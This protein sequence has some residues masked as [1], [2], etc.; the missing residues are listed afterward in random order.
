[1][2]NKLGCRKETVVTC[3]TDIYLEALSKMTL[4][5]RIQVD[6]VFGSPRLQLKAY[7][8]GS[9]YTSQA[10]WGGHDKLCLFQLLTEALKAIIAQNE[11]RGKIMNPSC[12][13]LQIGRA[14]V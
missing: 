11:L 1:M 6:R 4:K 10:T 7:F 3:V 5:V 12:Y 2:T 14:H 9:L 13:K 8:V